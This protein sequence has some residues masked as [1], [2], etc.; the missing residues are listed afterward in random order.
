MVMS[1]KFSHSLRSE[2]LNCSANKNSVNRDVFCHSLCITSRLYCKHVKGIPNTALRG[3]QV[4]LRW[5]PI[6]FSASWDCSWFLRS[7]THLLQSTTQYKIYLNC[8]FCHVVP[9]SRASGTHLSLISDPAVSETLNPQNLKQT[10]HDPQPYPNSKLET[11][12]F[13]DVRCVSS[14]ARRQA[15]LSW[16]VRT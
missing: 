1:I 15:S 11:P 12:P 8:A 16:R 5:G 7:S 6:N 4:H 14:T 13:H 10:K 9:L 2:V 3:R